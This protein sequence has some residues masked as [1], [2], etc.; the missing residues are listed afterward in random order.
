MLKIKGIIFGKNAIKFNNNMISYKKILGRK[1]DRVEAGFNKKI[2]TK[3]LFKKL[4]KIKN[5]FQKGLPNLS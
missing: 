2:V 1:I 3:Q 4:R 5:I